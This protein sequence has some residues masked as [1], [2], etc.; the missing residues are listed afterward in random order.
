[1]A[2][3]LVICEKPDAAKRIAESLGNKGQILRR[4]KR[5]VPVYEVVRPDETI[6]VCSAIGHLYSVGQ[7]QG[8]TRRACPVWDTA[9]KPR[10]LIERDQERLQTWIGQI[11]QLSQE[12]DRFVNAC[13]YDIEGSVIGAM[14]LKYACNGAHRNARRMKFSTLTRGELQEAYANLSAELDI[15]LVDAGMCRHEV[16][17][18]YGIN[19]SRALTASALE[20]GEVYSTLSTGRV[21]G[22]TLRFVVDREE[23]ISCF[24]PA[25]YWTIETVIR[26][27]GNTVSAEYEREKIGSKGEADKVITDCAGES[28]AIT[29]VESHRSRIYPPAPFDLSA[30][31]AEAYRH[32]GLRPS[33]TLGIAERLYLD[34]LISYPRT[35]SQ[36]LPPSI[37]YR[38]ILENLS[39]LREYA[40]RI[41]GILRLPSLS[42][43]EGERS[44][45]AHPAIYPT[46][47]MPQ[48]ALQPRELKI[49]DLIVRRFIATFGAPAERQSE[50]A[51]VSVK[52]HVFYLRGVRVLTRGWID[53]YEP[54][55]R[56]EET[57]LPPLSVGQTVEIA[58]IAAAEKLTQPPP[59]FNPSSLLRLMESQNIGTKATRA[60]IVDT[61]YDRGYVI[62]EGMT[63]TPLAINVIEV[64]KKYCPKIIETSFTRELEKKMQDIESG[65]EQ[66]E[67]VLVEAI[68]HLRP[69]MNELE[70]KTAEL[71]TELGKTIRETRLAQASLSVPCPQCNSRLVVVRNSKT[72]K[73]FIG[74]T[75]RWKEGCSFSLPLP[76]IGELTLL[77]RSCSKC[78][79][80][81]VM[82]KA[83]GR[84]PMISCPMCFK[85][86]RFGQA[87]Q[88]TQ[89]PG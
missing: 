47:N 26:V 25:P 30:L 4:T 29:N 62:G 37:G 32:F 45:P 77:K 74:C 56:L 88:S 82:V 64:L 24:V 10:H 2:K 6:Y 79:F 58:K 38:S 85:E 89:T 63:P 13:D 39:T 44:D 70:A 69:V 60:N 7:K 51:S 28:G 52:G 81:L 1:M 9:W 31:Q 57:P 21:Q 40:A 53:L 67:H 18:M 73:R 19:L 23:Q 71:G 46:G 68:E 87:K 78:G 33:F 36:K 20:H 55:A 16:D 41:S 5:G 86:K 35:S 27:G 84:R 76:Q 49:Y 17:W 80:Q 48:H 22:P 75:G 3:T 72:G 59:R 50:K 12:A 43:S 15:T 8:A 34:A 11:S 66:R 83:R 61:L 42:P 65:K 54:Y 14:I